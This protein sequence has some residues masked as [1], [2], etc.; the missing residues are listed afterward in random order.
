MLS[1]AKGRRGWGNRNLRGNQRFLFFISLVALQRRESWQRN[2][3]KV[4]V[5]T[6]WFCLSIHFTFMLSPSPP[7]REVF[8]A[9]L[10]K[11][12]SS[13][14]L[15]LLWLSFPLSLPIS[16]SPFAGTGPFLRA[17]NTQTRVRYSWCLTTEF[18]IVLALQSGIPWVYFTEK[19]HFL[20][21]EM[22]LLRCAEDGGCNKV[23]K[24]L[25]VCCV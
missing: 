11:H 18:F 19:M 3:A 2:Q 9:I 16:L 14:F 13:P 23:S 24:Y 1:R 25:L 7:E 17:S 12:Q 21:G 10:S 20:L 22:G 8:T 5:C 15:S 6:K 4:G